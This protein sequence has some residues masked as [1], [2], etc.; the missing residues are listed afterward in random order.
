[1]NA[2]P[3][4]LEDPHP[5]CLIAG[6]IGVTPI[7]T[8]GTALAAAQRPFTLHYSARTAQQLVLSGRMSK[9][10]GAS[11]RLYTDDDEA[12]ALNVDRLLD[13][14]PPVTPLYVCG[15]QG[16]IDAVRAGAAARGWSDKAIHFESF[17]PAG[18]Q[19]GDQPF[20]VE[21][22]STG[23]VVTVPAD[24]SLLD[25]LIE[26]DLFILYDC[27]GG[28]CGLCAVPV[29]AGE[30]DHRD[31]FLTDRDR[32]SNTVMQACVSRGKGRIRIDL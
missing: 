26:R 4:D 29:L 3:L 25:V 13:G 11:L 32:D 23:E 7:A 21:F 22:A 31:Q 9:V 27:K 6:G 20:D 17:L 16:M 12:H 18:P 10:M 30:V 24:K 8:M 15:P 14:L 19:E 5:P 28:T 2:F 1:V